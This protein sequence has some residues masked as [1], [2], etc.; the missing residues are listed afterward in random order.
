MPKEQSALTED[1]VKL[2]GQK[3]ALISAVGDTTGQKH[4]K[5]LWALK[6]RGVFENLEDAHRHARVLHDSDP[7]FDIYVVDLYRW[8]PFPP[9]R[10]KIAESSGEVYGDEQLNTLIQDYKENQKKVRQVFDQRKE[11]MLELARSGGAAQQ[12]EAG[13]SSS[14]NGPDASS[15]FET[16]DLSN[17]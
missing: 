15:T 16:I 3:F 8:L 9:D 6:I 1:T 7:L 5:N 10:E 14:A 17:A 11:D 12:L 13:E 4:E 2:A